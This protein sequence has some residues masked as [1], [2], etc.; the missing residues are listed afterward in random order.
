MGRGICVRRASEDRS[1]LDICRRKHDG[2]DVSCLSGHCFLS[3]GCETRGEFDLRH[4]FRLEISQ[5]AFFTRMLKHT[6]GGFYRESC[7]WAAKC[8]IET[9]TAEIGQTLAIRSIKINVEHTMIMTVE[10]M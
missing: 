7:T 9:F 8:P 6:S 3:V 4:H 10:D 1:K 2:R 5:K